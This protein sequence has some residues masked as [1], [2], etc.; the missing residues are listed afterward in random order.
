M[1]ESY[2]RLTDH[3]FDLWPKSQ[4]FILLFRLGD[5]RI[6]NLLVLILIPFQVSVVNKLL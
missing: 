6:I 1:L 3:L 2:A 5:L 4:V